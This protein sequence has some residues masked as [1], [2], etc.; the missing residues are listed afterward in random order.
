MVYGLWFMVYGLWFMVYGLW[1]RVQGSGFRVQGCTH[2]RVS[3]RLHMEHTG[4]H[5]LNRVL[6]HNNNAVEKCQP[7]LRGGALHSLQRALHVRR[8]GLHTHH[9]R[10]LSGWLHGRPE[11]DLWVALTPGGCQVGCMGDQ[12]STYGLHS[13]PGGGRLVAWATRTRLMGCTHSRGVSGWLHHTC[14]HQLAVINRC[15]ARKTT[16]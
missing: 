2:S 16:W 5:Q 13:L 8:V 4:C 10:G 7:Y 9:S 11:L 12:N 3:G 14:C 6:T 15:F 1:F